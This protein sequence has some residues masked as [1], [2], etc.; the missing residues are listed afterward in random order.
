MTRYDPS[1]RLWAI[2]QAERR[3]KAR[4][5][6]G[7]GPFYPRRFWN[8]RYETVERQAWRRLGRLLAFLVWLV[9]VIG[10]IGVLGFMLGLAGG[11][12]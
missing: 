4:S 12:Q 6:W 8:L 7:A 2:R 1:N 9:L 5:S 10:S 3:A 11:A